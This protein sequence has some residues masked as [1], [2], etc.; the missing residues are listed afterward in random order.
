M[1]KDWGH[2]D[3]TS[4]KKD[5]T[6]QGDIALDK[7]ACGAV[8]RGTMNSDYNLTRLVPALVGKTTDGKKRCDDGGITHPDNILGLSNGSLLVA[9]DACKKT[10]PV[11]MLWLQK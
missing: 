3:W 11:D 8:Y 7:E 4:G 1:V 10:H 6:F 2:V 5:L 9:E